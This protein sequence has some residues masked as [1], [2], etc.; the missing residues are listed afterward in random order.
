MSIRH[1]TW[2]KRVSIGLLSL[3]SLLL[4][5]SPAQASAATA[6][7]NGFQISPVRSELTI[8]KGSSQTVD[9]TVTNPTASALN[10]QA[11][12]N[13]FV[14][15][16]DESGD[17]RLLLNGGVASPSHDFKKLVNNI[18]NVSLAAGATKEIAVTIAVPSNAAS[19]GYY[20]A[21][22]FVP[23]ATAQSGNVGLTAS[24]GTL[25][26]ITVPGNLIEKLNLVQLSAGHT[27]GSTSSILTGGKVAIIS[28]LQNTGDIHV[29]PFGTVEI[30]NMFGK[31]VDEYQ[32]NNTQP[33]ANI[34]PDSIRRFTDPLSYSHWFGRYTIE[35]NL[36]YT[37]GSGNILT[38]SASFWYLPL[39]FVLVVVGIIFVIVVW[40]YYMIYRKR[41]YHRH[42]S[43]R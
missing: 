39:W 29:Q 26:L 16:S 30:K 33:R 19:G 20:G 13:D 15:S 12:V 5:V 23:L 18:P 14:A 35:E 25:F 7:G 28:R 1:K 11:I 27:D 24:V 4:L 41:H 31:I 42:S 2:G 36:A 6:T 21:V 10:A 34:L 43:R 9:V 40:I 8:S 38:G 3:A 37:S 17:P 22:R 32:F